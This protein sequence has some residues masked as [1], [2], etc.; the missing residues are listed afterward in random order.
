MPARY[1]AHVLVGPPDF[2]VGISAPTSLY[3][4]IENI[5]DKASSSFLPPSDVQFYRDIWPVLEATYNLSWVNLTA[6]QGHGMLSSVADEG[7]LTRLL[8]NRSEWEGQ[9]PSP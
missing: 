4:V 6:F 2:A 7:A 1:K 8:S 9:L 5:Y 3:D